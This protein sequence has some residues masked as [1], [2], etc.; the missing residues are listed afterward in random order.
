MAQVKIFWDPNGFE[1]DSLG[2]KELL[3]ITDGDT[4]YVSM[5]IRMLSIDTPEVHYPG[6]QKPSRQDEKLAQLADWLAAG[7]APVKDGLAKYLHPRLATGTAGTLQENQGEAATDEFQK[8]LDEK[9]TRPDGS[10]RHVFLRAADQPFDQYG[11]ILAYIAPYYSK[12][13]LDSLSLRER[14]SFN[15]LM[16]ASGWAVAFPIYPSIPKYADLVLLQEVGRDAFR[17][18]KGAWA[19]A[20]ILTGYEFR[21]C[22]KL[23]NVTK[24]L[25]E[26]ESLSSREKYGWISRYCVDMTSREIFEPQDYHRVAPW[27]RIFIWPEDV[28]AAVGKM[29]LVPAEQR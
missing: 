9:L 10:K 3:R 6:R 26:G 8:L 20:M 15:L 27:N 5:S 14:A 2:S 21:M 4:P 29:N 23:Y 22:V 11:R 16:V 19:D 18:K 25:V 28:A 12:T 24:R 13:E 1:L 7:K 17:G